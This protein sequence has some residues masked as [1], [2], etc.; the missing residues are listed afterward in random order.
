LALG[1]KGL[2][3]FAAAAVVVAA[4]AGCGSGGKSAVQL[5]VT[6]KPAGGKALVFTASTNKKLASQKGGLYALE[7]RGIDTD[8]AGASFDHPGYIDP[9][10]CIGGSTCQWTVVPA[11]AARYEF[12][13]FLLDYVHDNTAGE[14]N[15]VKL[16]WA[17]PPRPAAIKLFVNGKTP[18]S[19]SLAADHYSDFPAGPMQVEAKWTTDARDTGYYV[20][21]SVDGRVYA[22]CSTGTACPVS[23]RL[24]LNVGNEVSWMLELVTT[25]GNKVV[26]GFKVCL[27]GAKKQK[28]A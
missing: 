2:K 8:S 1:V 13:V 10:R 25:R 17:A 16:R 4:A 12:K 14:S 7:L 11:K 21:I 18:P 15:A 20:R 22:R 27:E 28:A 23:Q 9:N 26:G 3:F 24:P 5:E 19:V 6:T